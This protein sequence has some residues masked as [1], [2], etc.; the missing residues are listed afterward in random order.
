M[1]FSKKETNPILKLLIAIVAA[2]LVLMLRLVLP[3]DGI[4][5]IE[6]SLLD[7][8]Y[9]AFLGLM[10]TIEIPLVFLSVACGIIVLVTA[11]FSEK[12]GAR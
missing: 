2:F 8:L 12:S 9:N 1:R 7:P 6:D 4:A 10:A 3:A 11:P 5:F